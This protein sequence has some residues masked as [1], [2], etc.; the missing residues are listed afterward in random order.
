M[1]SRS[2]YVGIDLAFGKGKRLPLA[3]VVRAE[4]GL[5]PLAL[6]SR[7]RPRPPIGRG[8]RGTLDAGVVADFCAEVEAYLDAVAQSERLVIRRI[9]IDAPS[10]PCPEALSRRTCERAM[11]A[12]G[13]G[14]FTTPRASAFR[15]IQDRAR[16][17]L[18]RGGP[19]ARLPHAHQLF[20]AVGFALFRRLERRFE[21][22]EV[23]PQAAVAALGAGGVHKTRPEGLARQRRAVAGVFDVSPAELTRWIETAGYGAGHDRLD[24]LICAWIASLPRRRLDACGSGAGD[25][26]W[27]PRIRPT[28]P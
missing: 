5:R 27:V 6:R 25:V 24:A 8:N 2:A 15:E 20:M 9:A 14:V 17:H 22:R 18:A 23:F 13:L 1:H 3:I 11:D 28:P 7:D 26:I 10:A 12:R 21:C 4:G 16:R 19:E